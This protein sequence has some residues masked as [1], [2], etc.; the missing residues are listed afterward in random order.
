MY[1]S[2]QK[3][4]SSNEQMKFEVKN[5]LLFTLAPPPPLK[6]KYS[7]INLAK[8]VRDLHGKTTKL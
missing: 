7:G 4:E 8:Y 5:S 2:E 6:G 3:S 1:F